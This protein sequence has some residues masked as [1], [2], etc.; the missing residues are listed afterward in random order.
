LELVV[1]VPGDETSSLEKG[2][3][4]VGEVVETSLL[5]QSP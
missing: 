2:A 3:E 1:T 4:M 5:W